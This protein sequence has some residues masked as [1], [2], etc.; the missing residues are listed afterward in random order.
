VARRTSFLLHFQFVMVGLGRQRWKT[1]IAFMHKSEYGVDA[2][3]KM[4]ESSPR[5]GPPRT[6]ANHDTKWQ[7]QE[8][9]RK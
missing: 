7:P 4:G 9:D 3:A 5:P 6:E 8:E 1:S 2:V